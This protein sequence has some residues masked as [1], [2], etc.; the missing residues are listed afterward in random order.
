[1]ASTSVRAEIGAGDL[2][3]S[4]IVCCYNRP[5]RLRTCLDA[6]LQQSLARQK[7]EIVVVDN[8]SDDDTPDVAQ[9]YARSYDHVR[10]LR[11]PQLGLSA[12]RN[13]GVQAAKGTYVAFIDDDAV[14]GEAWLETILKAFENAPELPG[15]V[16]GPIVPVW[17]AGRP[18]WLHPKL[19]INYSIYDY[20]DEVCF[21]SDDVILAG[22]NLAFPR[23]LIERVGGFP[24][25]LDRRGDNL[26]SGGDTAVFQAVCEVGYRPLY[27]PEA[28]VW[29]HIPAERCRKRWILRRV[30]WGGASG[31][32][33]RS[34]PESNTLAERLYR[35]ARA[36]YHLMRKPATYSLL[37]PTDD[38]ERFLRKTDVYG[39]I[40]KLAA[41]LGFVR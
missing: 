33:L 14:A 5:N 11:E 21:L 39:H 32:L 36:G 12:A 4:A 9:E 6:L 25:H 28:T 37:V 15:C 23:V 29:H 24:I 7:H 31:V 35:T 26:R 19:D 38:P 13:T 34:R 8:A 2:P 3:I 18:D 16:T 40:G 22:A 41:L 17:E 30:F 10:A 20:G 27:H 1:M